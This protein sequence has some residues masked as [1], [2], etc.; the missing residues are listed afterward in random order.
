M[1]DT[2]TRT[3][4]SSYQGKLDTKSLNYVISPEVQYTIVMHFT[5][6]MFPASSCIATLASFMAFCSGFMP[7]SGAA[8]A[9]RIMR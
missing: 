4:Y 8:A 9:I 7:P 2:H 5:L 3:I 6:C 1:R